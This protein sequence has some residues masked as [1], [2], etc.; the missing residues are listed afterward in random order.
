MRNRLILASIAALLAGCATSSK[1]ITAAY[2]SP[3]QYE[4][5]DCDQIS[6]EMVR[7][8]ARTTELGG[9]LDEA[10]AN[11]QGIAVAG[12]ILFWPALFFLGGTQ[13]QEAEYARLK[14]EHEALHQ[15]AIAKKCSPASTIQPAPA[16]EAPPASNTL[17]AG[18]RAIEPVAPSQQ[19]VD[20]EPVRY[21]L[22]P[23]T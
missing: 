21:R 12:A 9:R 5:H 18:N 11:D 20:S 22:L 10:A 16:N 6:M 7:I 1:D 3:L 2:V 19:E 15:Q 13:A 4:K 17:D 23:V 8:Q 14:G